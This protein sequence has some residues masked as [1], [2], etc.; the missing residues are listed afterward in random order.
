MA[1]W[2]VFIRANSLRLVSFRAYV[3]I[4]LHRVTVCHITRKE[5]YIFMIKESNFAPH[6]CGYFPTIK[7]AGYVCKWQFIGTQ[8][9]ISSISGAYAC[10]KSY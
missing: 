2:L 5:K 7:K 4:Y 3:S 9:F 1:L 8:Q 6:Y 10:K